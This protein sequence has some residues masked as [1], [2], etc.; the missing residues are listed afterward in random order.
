MNTNR[1]L[2]LII[3]CVLF[4][5][6]NALLAKTAISGCYGAGNS[7]S[8]VYRVNLQRAWHS[9]GKASANQ[10]KIGGYWELAFTKITRND[11]VNIPNNNDAQIFSLSAALRIPYRFILDWVVDVGLGLA[12]TSN[13]IVVGRDLGSKFVFEDRVGISILPG[14]GHKLEVGYRFIHYSNA[15]L[16]QKNQ[17]LNLHLFILGYWFY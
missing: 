6:S 1:L 9:G 5:T 10:R 16:A 17:A 8:E 12:N 3:G 11:K 15:Y 13:R 14:R 2:Y 4:I 7:R